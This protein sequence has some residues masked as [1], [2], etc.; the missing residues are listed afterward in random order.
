MPTYNTDTSEVNFGFKYPD[1]SDPILS[2]LKNTAKIDLNSKDSELEKVKTITGYAHSLFTHSGDNTPSSYDPLTIIKE[3]QAGKSF[4]CAEYSLLATALLWAYAIPARPVG[5]KTSD[6]ETRRYGA[7]HV[8]IEF[9]SSELRK[10]IMCDV[11]AGIFTQAGNVLLSAFELGQTIS[12][13]VTPEYMPVQHSRFSADDMF[14]DI[15]AYIAWIKEYLYFFDT[16]IQMTFADVDRQKQQIA[17]L[18]PL[19]VE[20]PKM[21]QGLF[22]MN[23]IYT[24]S[25]LDFY[26]KP[27]SL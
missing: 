27:T 4:R 5:L 6:V 16:P 25:V 21:F 14:A 19:G 15:T 23:A 11:Q 12:Q 3:A 9:W 18:V 8:V 17:M 2:K 20:P 24:H 22:E 26:R 7:G 1:I 13:K 10:W